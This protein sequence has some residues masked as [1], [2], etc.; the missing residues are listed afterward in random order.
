MIEACVQPDS[1]PVVEQRSFVSSAEAPSVRWH[2]PVANTVSQVTSTVHYTGLDGLRRRSCFRSPKPKYYGVSTSFLPF[3]LLFC[4]KTY[5]HWH[6]K[7]SLI[8]SAK[9][10]GHETKLKP[11][12]LPVS[13]APWTFICTG[14]SC[15]KTGREWDKYLPAYLLGRAGSVI[16]SL[17]TSGIKRKTLPSPHL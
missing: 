3:C 5:Q 1:P 14:L 15:V 8:T 16:N 7:I 6:F 12:R 11:S 13:K 9:I 17:T 4:A 10:P 2:Y